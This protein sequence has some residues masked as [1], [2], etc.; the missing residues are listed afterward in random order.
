M[1][2]FKHTNGSCE[3]SC[4]LRLSDIGVS[5]NG[6]Q[7]I[8]DVN[9]HLHCGEIAALIGPNGV[10]KSTLLKAILGQTAHTGK[11]EFQAASGSNTRPLIGYVPHSPAFDPSDP[12]SVLD[13]FASCISKHP[14]FLPVGKKLRKRV[15]DC[16]AKVRAEKLIDKRI[17]LLSGGELQRVLLAMALEP[18]PQILILDEP[19]NAVDVQG[20]AM[21]MEMLDEIRRKYDLSILMTTHDFSMLEP[22]VDKVYLLS[23]TIISAGTPA[24]V[25]SRDEFRSVFRL[26]KRKGDE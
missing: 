4:C 12:V 2:D 5:I 1:R 21:L 10:G 14:V 22:Y 7:L 9:I 16:L 3:G 17:G 8:S 13:L 11:I 15:E 19:M 23:G 20:I 26:G 24:E 6:Q 18:L 25:L